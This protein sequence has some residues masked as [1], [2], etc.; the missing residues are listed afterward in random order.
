[1]IFMATSLHGCPSP[2]G[3]DDARRLP[4]DRAGG[5]L[6]AWEM[7]ALGFRYFAGRANASSL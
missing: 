7:A 2:A 6:L 1:M 5:C 3:R 4:V